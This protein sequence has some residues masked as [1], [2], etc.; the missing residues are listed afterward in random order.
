MAG[1]GQL[2]A[3]GQRC[4]AQVF[5][6][7]SPSGQALL[8]ETALGLMA[9][10]VSVRQ[11]WLQQH[12]PTMSIPITVTHTMGG[13]ARDVARRF[14]LGWQIYSHI[15]HLETL[16]R[17]DRF[18]GV[19]LLLLQQTEASFLAA[20]ILAGGVALFTH[21][22]KS[23]PVRVAAAQEA[24]HAGAAASAARASALG[25]FS[26]V[27]GRPDGMGLCFAG[28]FQKVQQDAADLK[29]SVQEKVDADRWLCACQASAAVAL[30]N[31]GKRNSNHRAT[32]R[33][34]AVRLLGEGVGAA[35]MG[36]EHWAQYI[37]KS[38][39][40]MQQQDKPSPFTETVQLAKKRS[41]G[42]RD[43]WVF[44]HAD[45]TGPRWS[46]TDNITYRLPWHTEEDPAL[47]TETVRAAISEA[48]HVNWSLLSKLV[49]ADKQDKA[50][51]KLLFRGN[52]KS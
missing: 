13:F 41:S 36:Q 19:S 47:H 24:R 35:V 7:F 29:L 17:A 27:T 44:D 31:R 2:L 42:E 50:A 26:S 6:C 21:E 18:F 51:G 52:A 38:A 48:Y 8:A 39:K 40:K 43:G 25:V 12:H 3:G 22:W 30:V 9:V 11:A 32:S 28:S 15:A 1:R 4:S 34:T 46:M 5:G 45:V 33:N 10:I 20:F 49:R 16:L 23:N 37:T 14:S